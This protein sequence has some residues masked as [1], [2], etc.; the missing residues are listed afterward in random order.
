MNAKHLVE[1]DLDFIA[2]IM[3]NGGDSLKKCF[4]CA[5][6]SVACKLSS[7]QHPFPRKEMIS[8]AWG[9]KD[10]LV[11]NPDIWQCHN[12]GDCSALCPR[13]ARPGDT[14]GAVRQ[15]AIKT[16]ARP[17]LLGRLWTDPR[18]LPLLFILPTLVILAVGWGTGLLNLQPDGGPIVYACYFPVAL[19]EMIFIPLTL[20]AGAVFFFGIRKMLADMQAYDRRQGMATVPFAP[21]AFSK[22]NSNGKMDGRL[23]G[24][25]CQDAPHQLVRGCTGGINDKMG[26]FA[27]QQ[28]TLSI[29]IRQGLAG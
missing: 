25:L 24:Q 13:G 8:A 2:A 17:A 20:L 12:C 6:C 11:G 9:L 28:Q 27:V 10:R 22:S 14:L 29:K 3:Q 5:T 1:P 16:Y 26:R 4:Q 18:M 19:I 7:D 15:I 23:S 21:I